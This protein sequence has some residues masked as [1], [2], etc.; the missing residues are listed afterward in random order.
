MADHDEFKYLDPDK[1]GKLMRT[2][3]VL[4]TRNILDLKSGK[5]QAFRRNC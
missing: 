2:K 4:D 3:Q 1:L 5:K